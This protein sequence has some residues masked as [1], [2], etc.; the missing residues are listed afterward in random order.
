MREKGQFLLN[1][2]NGIF[3]LELNSDSGLQWLATSNKDFPKN[4]IVTEMFV[5]DGKID[6]KSIRGFDFC[7]TTPLSEDQKDLLWV[8]KHIH[9]EASAKIVDFTDKGMPINVQAVFA[10]AV[11]R[12][13]IEA[14][15]RHGM[16]YFVLTDT[17][18]VML[19]EL[20]R[21]SIL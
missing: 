2:E 5:T 19:K 9:M 10:D 1:V 21:D 20:R 14:R 15:E 7:E 13:F 6:M 3:H 12:G 17:G 11:R 16:H 8:L 18:D 4:L